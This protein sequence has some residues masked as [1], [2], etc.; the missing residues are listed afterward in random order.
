MGNHGR[1]RA[2]KE[3]RKGREKPELNTEMPK[4]TSRLPGTYSAPAAFIT[5]EHRLILPEF[6]IF[7]K[8]FKMQMFR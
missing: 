1:Q 6:L 8:Q 5:R 4:A 7:L 3:D 2:G